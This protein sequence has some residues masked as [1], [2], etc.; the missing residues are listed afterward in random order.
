MLAIQNNLVAIQVKK[1]IQRSN[2]TKML[3]RM[4]LHNF[5]VLAISFCLHVLFLTK[6]NVTMQEFISE[7]SSADQS[8]GISSTCCSGNLGSLKTHLENSKMP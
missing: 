1:R 4:F 2:L 8:P 3:L 6:Q 7:Y 5:C